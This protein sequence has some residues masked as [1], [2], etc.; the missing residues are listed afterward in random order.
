MMLLCAAPA[1]GLTLSSQL[2]K[3]ALSVSTVLDAV[4]QE[5]VAGKL[6]IRRLGLSCDGDRECLAR[7]AREAGLPALVSVSIA[8][9]KKHS[10]LDLEAVRAVDGVS[11]AQLTFTFSGR[12]SEANREAMRGFAARVV[13]A[14]APPTSDQPRVEVTP[15][16]SGAPL[17]ALPLEPKPEFVSAPLPPV[18]HSRVPAWVLGGGALAAGVVSGVFL[19]TASV[20]NEQLQV[21][22]N[23]LTREAAGGLANQANAEY[24]VS[25]AAG[26]AAGALATGAVLWLVTE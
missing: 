25:L 13:E 8:W 18:K 14:L 4:E 19:A 9:S 24:T 7:A 5:L 3:S 16:T 22:P 21:N 23:P 1:S 12:F 6:P 15:P 10:T 20:K 2:G 26:L 11:L 17:P